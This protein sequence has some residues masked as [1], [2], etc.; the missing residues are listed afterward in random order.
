M[1]HIT[2]KDALEANIEPEEDFY[3]VAIDPPISEL[4]F[5]EEINPIQ[6]NINNL[7]QIH[8]TL[9][10]RREIVKNIKLLGIDAGCIVVKRDLNPYLRI[11]PHS[12]GIVQDIVTYIAG[13]N[14]TFV[15]IEVRW[16][17]GKTSYH[18]ESDLIVV[19]YPPDDMELGQIMQGEV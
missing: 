7:R 2:T 5:E 9:E 8:S 1:A 17:N 15:P 18:H 13:E 10:D 16:L 12:W 11:E 4:L 3:E 19:M 14:H 6:Q